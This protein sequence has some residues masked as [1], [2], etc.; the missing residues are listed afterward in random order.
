MML[1]DPA[2]AGFISLT[3]LQLCFFYIHCNTGINVN[4]IIFKDDYV[5]KG[6]VCNTTFILF[7]LAKFRWHRF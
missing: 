4:N 1:S 3:A 6:A 5:N 7:T 2:S